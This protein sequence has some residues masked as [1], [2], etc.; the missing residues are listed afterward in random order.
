LEP[1][2]FSI[3]NG[4]QI[5]QKILQKNQ[6]FDEEDQYA[7]L[8]QLQMRNFDEREE[9]K[10]REKVEKIVYE[11][12]SR[13]RQLEDEARRKREEKRRQ[14]ELDTILV[15]RI[16][17][18]EQE[19]ESLQLQRKIQGIE[20]FKRLK[21]ENETNKHIAVVRANEEKQRYRLNSGTSRRSSTT[22]ACSTSRS[23]RARTSSRGSSYFRY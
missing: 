4:R 19:A 14:K 12:K 17:E 21:D 22:A 7:N 13:D 3:F 2:S 8:L 20:H 10:K 5:Q 15:Q 1:Q 9:L 18:E 6:E 16:K 23:A 11:K